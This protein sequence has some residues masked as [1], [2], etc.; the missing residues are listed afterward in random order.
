MGLIVDDKLKD[1]ILDKIEIA[2]NG[3]NFGNGRYIDKLI[4]KLLLEH[5]VNV[6]DNKRKDKLIKLTAKDFIDD[7]EETL[8]YKVKTKKIGF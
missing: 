3:K 5:S 7:L 2:K 6:K 8:Q 4:D 1:I